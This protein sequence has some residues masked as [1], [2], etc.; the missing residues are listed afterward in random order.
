M[1]SFVFQNATKIIFGKDTEK[2]VGSELKKEG[3]K[4]ILLIYGG[5]SI[6]KSGLF[7]R[8]EASLKENGI[9]FTELGGVV[10]NPRIGLVREGSKLCREKNI[11]FIL[12]VGGG[13]VI[14]S[15]KA[16]SFGAC[17]DGDPWDFFSGKAEPGENRIPLATILTIPAAGSEASDSCV[18]T[19]EEL[20][21][22]THFASPLMR[23]VFSIMNP[24]LTFSLPPYQTACGCMDIMAHVME[25]YFTKT[26]HV[27]L[28][29]RLCESVLKT[30]IHNL[31]IVLKEPENYDARAEIMWAGTIAHNDLI[32]MGRSHCWF[33]HALEH[34][35]SGYYD[36]PH[37][38]G[39]A[40]TFPAWMK[41]LSSKPECQRRLC[42]FATNVWGV[43]YN[44][45]N[46]LD[47]IM[48]GIERLYSFEKACGLPVSLNEVSIGSEK[49][50]LMADN[51]TGGGKHPAWGFYPLEKSDII[52]I[53]KL[54]SK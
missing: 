48:Q 1:D 28:A 35:I 30:V 37:G 53:L 17:Y 32:G 9:G 21:I 25:R 43:E 6:K 40:I 2:L 54:A 33:N 19:N 46:P 34:Q 27:E 29:D 4:N 8:V 5:G 44:Y 12:A 15:A 11:D 22:K 50:E 51:L 41:H 47:T 13:S 20:N 39:L 49:F 23:P 42:Q 24:E 26:S 38:A 14:D 18:I 10:P 16:I 45:D 31:P 36:I 7:G 3:A 52:E